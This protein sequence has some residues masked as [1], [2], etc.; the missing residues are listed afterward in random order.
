VGELRFEELLFIRIAIIIQDA[1][2]RFICEGL[3]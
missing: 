2:E 3:N 1:K